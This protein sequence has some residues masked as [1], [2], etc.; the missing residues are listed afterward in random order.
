MLVATDIAIDIG[1]NDLRVFL[2][3]RGLAYEAPCC[4]NYNIS[5]NGTASF[6]NVGNV[7]F[8]DGHIVHSRLESW[9]PFFSDY[10][11]C[12]PQA[13][14]KRKVVEDVVFG[15]LCTSWFRYPR[16]VVVAERSHLSETDYQ[17]LQELFKDHGA[18]QCLR[19]P[20]AIASGMGSMSPSALHDVVVI[21]LSFKVASLTNLSAGFPVATTELPADILTPIVEYWRNERNFEIG[22]LTA[23]FIHKEARN[24]NEFLVPVKGL[25]HEVTRERMETS[26]LNDLLV[27]IAKHV[28]ESVR[29]MISGPP[30]GE[31]PV[32]ANYKILLTGDGA[33]FSVLTDLLGK[34][35]EA[36]GFTLYISKHPTQDAVLGLGQI[37]N[38]ARRGYKVP[39][40]RQL[41]A[42]NLR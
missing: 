25:D 7:G 30:D 2:T 18:K 19:L 1:R 3:N 20:A 21:D 33:Q 8:Y 36:E 16:S 42:E 38:V 29:R 11:D 27:P 6:I 32:I 28:T 4:I 40:L 13:K 24:H 31:R 9:N 15:E 37:L 22:F 12:T 23:I 41:F 39:G 34:L 35:F 10:P 5:A 14:A 17:L 26:V